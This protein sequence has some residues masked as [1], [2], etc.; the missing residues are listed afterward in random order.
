VRMTIL[1]SH[2]RTPP[3]ISIM[4]RFISNLLIKL[5]G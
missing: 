1:A 5:I 2:P 4:I 3:T